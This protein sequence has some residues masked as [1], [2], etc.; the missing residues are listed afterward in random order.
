MDNVQLSRVNY[1]GLIDEAPE[2][3][4]IGSEQVASLC[5]ADPKGLGKALGL[6][7]NLEALNGRQRK[8]SLQLKTFLI[9]TYFLSSVCMFKKMNGGEGVPWKVRCPQS[10][11]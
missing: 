10:Q 6:P 7:G 4:V 11:K 8:T 5:P 9:K 3:W 2:T 1:A